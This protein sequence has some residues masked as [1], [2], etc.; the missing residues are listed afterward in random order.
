[1]SNVVTLHGRCQACGT[2]L[3]RRIQNIFQRLCA[4]CFD[5]AMSSFE[6]ERKVFDALLAMGVDRDTS[7]AMMLAKH[8]HEDSR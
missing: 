5:A 3:R 7:N 1:M 8:A 4:G 2:P 6:Q